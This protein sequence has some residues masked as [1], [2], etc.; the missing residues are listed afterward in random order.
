MECIGTVGWISGTHPRST[1]DHQVVT[2]WPG[3]CPP[4]ALG[5]KIPG[6]GKSLG[7]RGIYFPIHPSSRQCTDTIWYMVLSAGTVPLWDGTVPSSTVSCW[8]VVWCGGVVWSYDGGVWW[9]G[10]WC[11]NELGR[12]PPTH[13]HSPLHWWGW[14][15]QPQTQ[16]NTKNHKQTNIYIS[17]LLSNA[18]LACAQFWWGRRQD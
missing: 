1:S 17:C 9:S 11:S 16:T 3:F 7:S 14:G 8:C 13:T 18:N 5:C 10:V 4:R 12:H 2:N 6:L 15:G